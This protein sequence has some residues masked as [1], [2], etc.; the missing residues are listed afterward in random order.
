MKRIILAVVLDLISIAALF[1]FLGFPGTDTPP[2]K[3]FLQ[4]LLCETGE[5]LRA[6]THSGVDSDGDMVTSTNYFCQP[7]GGDGPERDVTGKSVLMAIAAFLVPFGI[8]MLLFFSGG[9]SL[10]KRYAGSMTS[11]MGQFESL[12]ASAAGVGGNPTERLK[13]LKQAYDQGLISED[14]YERK[15][16]DVLKTM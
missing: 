4:S 13:A 16:Q 7:F 14:E 5:T 8:S 9:F 12:S 2:V 6:E 1:V 10:K 11:M 3:N 15:R